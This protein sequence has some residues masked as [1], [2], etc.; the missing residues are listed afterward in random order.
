MDRDQR[1]SA[2]ALESCI[3]C[4]ALNPRSWLAGYCPPA[5]TAKRPFVD[6]DPSYNI[7]CIPAGEKD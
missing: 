5:G 1:L 2:P 4:A 7:L 3:S 6:S